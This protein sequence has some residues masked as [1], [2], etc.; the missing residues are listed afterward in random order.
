[1]FKYRDIVL[2]LLPPLTLKAGTV[3]KEGVKAFGKKSSLKTEKPFQLLNPV[4]QLS[5]ARWV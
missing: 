4:Y 1:M 2:T 3:Y 5:T